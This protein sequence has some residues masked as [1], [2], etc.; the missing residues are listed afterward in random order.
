VRIGTGLSQALDAREGALAAAGAARDGLGGAA[1]DIAMVFASGAHLADPDVTLAAVHEVLAPAALAGCGAGGVLA[2][3]VEVERGTSVSVW[4][5]ALEGG[6]AETFALEADDVVPGLDSAS[7]L[8]L[9]ADPYTFP[10]DDALAVMH[11]HAPEVPVLGGISSARTLD[12]GAALFCDAEV[13][14]SGA[15]GIRF[16]DV[17]VRACVSQ[18]AAPVGPELTITSCDGHVVHE[19]AGRPA[20]TKLREVVLELPE[21]ER[22]LVGRGLLLGIVVNPNKP[23]YVQGDFLVRGLLGADP[24]SGSVTVGTEVQPGTVV[25]LHARDAELA[26]RDLR[27]ALTDRRATLPGETAGALVF[28]C[29]GRGT[30]MFGTAGHDAR[31]VDEQL[32][33]APAAGFF[34]AGEIGPVGGRP[35][36]HGFTATIAVFG[37]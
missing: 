17:D 8:V 3:R 22:E 29:N 23:D 25:R 20:L 7:A 21:D 16:A 6:R 34:A 4:A 9:L 31:T 32:G 14:G 19:L 35:F 12:G 26:G 13:L 27:D 24:D 28:A 15:V 1:C 36:L 5:A 11:E 37:R 2:T 33:G 30:A 18:G 10:A